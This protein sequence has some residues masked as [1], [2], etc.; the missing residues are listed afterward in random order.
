MYCCGCPDIACAP[1]DCV[2]HCC[3]WD[4][5]DFCLD[6]KYRSYKG[7]DEKLDCC[8]NGL[9]QCTIQY[10]VLGCGIGIN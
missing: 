8:S 4:H 2:R 7:I 6:C 10:F 3:H 5:E 1:E 9:L